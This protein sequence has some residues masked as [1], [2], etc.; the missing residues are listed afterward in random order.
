MSNVKNVIRGVLAF[1]VLAGA[2]A[3]S[4]QT[5]DEIISKHLAAVGGKDAIGQVK[6]MSMETSVQVM[7]NDAPSSTVI[8]DGVGYK[9]ETDF[10]GSKIVQCYNDKGGW[11]V[12]PMAGAADPAPMTDDEYKAGKAQIYVGGALY[13][14]AAKGSKAELV[15]KDAD[16][17]KIKMTTKENSE[18]TYVID[19]KTYYVKSVTMKGSMQG[20]AVDVTTSFSD[21][22][23]SDLGYVIPYAM[24]VDLGGQ[25]SLSITV[26]KVEFN[27]TID[28][29]IFSMPK[30]S[31]PATS[32]GKGI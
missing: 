25:F 16:T 24:D 18:S 28:P 32:P 17:Y 22:R 7:G 19:A 6:S 3:L 13:D 23:K 1:S 29:A 20:Q 21:Y 30:A 10:N 5:A 14:Y 9:T 2:C 11:N 4:A 12:N 31:A 8:V 27:K 15:S 26:K